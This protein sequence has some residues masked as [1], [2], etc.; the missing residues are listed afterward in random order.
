M[1]FYL[2]TS[3]F[4][5]LVVEEAESATL[6]AWSTEPV[7]HFVSSDLLRTEALR[8]ARRH[9]PEALLQARILLDGVALMAVTADVCERAAELD[10]SILRSLDALHLASALMLGDSLEGVV[11]YDTRFASACAAIGI[12]VVAPR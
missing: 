3:A 2:D 10:P 8:T 9:S 6:R 7:K 5:K 4:L 12:P 11:T 1:A